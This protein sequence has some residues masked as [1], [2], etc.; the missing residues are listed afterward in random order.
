MIEDLV[1]ELIER[2][3]H[4]YY[5]KYRG[6]VHDVND[7]Q[8]TGRIRAMVPRLL[9]DTPTGWALPCAPFAGPDQGFFAIPDV[10]A[11]VWIEFEGGDLSRP[12]WSGGWWGS[13]VQ[14]D[15][16]QGSSAESLPPAAEQVRPEGAAADWTPPTV[17]P[18]TPQADYSPVEGL[19]HQTASPQVRLFKSATGHHIVLDD[20]PDHERIE[21]H[22]SRGNRLIFS[23]EGLDRIMSSERT[24]NKGGRSADID[25]ADFLELG[26][27]QRELIGGGHER[28]VDGDVEWAFEGNFKEAAR[29]GEYTREIDERGTRVS[30]SGASEE[31]HR[32][33]LERTVVGAAKDTYLGGY[34]LTSVGATSITTAGPIKLSGGLADLSL[35]VFAVDGLLGNISLNSK[36]GVLQAG[37]MTAISPM[38][39]GDGLMIQQTMLSQTLKLVYPPM[40]LIYGPVADVW[41]AMTPVLDLSMYG[42]VKRFPVG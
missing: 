3:D 18:E 5:G 31:F 6:Y 24:Y 26:G 15:L 25:G 23:A 2:L 42:F 36:L 38:V 12:I 14:D 16:D 19:K 30:Q 10:G 27:N 22:D 35:N 39:L 8:N 21:I 20:R 40:A 9:N 4:R 1:Q 34:S 33:S 7:P 28:K 11:G 29:G 17:T 37:G 32:G 13:P 41:A